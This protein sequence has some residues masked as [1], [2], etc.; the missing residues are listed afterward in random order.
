VLLA[1]GAAL[2]YGWA[3][4]PAEHQAQAWNAAG[5][6]VRAGLLLAVLWHVR[7]RFALPVLA[8][9]LAEESLVAGC[10]LAYIVK[11][12]EVL[13]DQAQCSALLQH[14]LGVYGLVAIVAIVA[15]LPVKA[16]SYAD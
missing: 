2:H 3:L 9:W 11:P 7:S 4:V 6:A 16:D 15:A 12:W 14:D 10:S 1:A 13:P 5:A 8:W